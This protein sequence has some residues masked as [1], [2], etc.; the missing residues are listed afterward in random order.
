MTTEMKFGLWALKPEGATVCWGARAIVEESY[1]YGRWI[2]HGG[3]G[4]RPPRY[5]IS[6]VW[7][8]QSWEGDSPAERTVLSK[9]LNAVLPAAL[10]EA[11]ACLDNGAWESPMGEGVRVLYSDDKIEII[12][13]PRASGGYVYM[14]GYWKAQPEAACAGT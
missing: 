11:A 3:R 2:D 10:A 6:L 14:L 9:A 12:G 4:K 1:K 5:N 8:R 13:D 7:D